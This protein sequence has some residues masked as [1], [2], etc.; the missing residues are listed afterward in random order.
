M[1]EEQLEIQ[2]GLFHG[3]NY[4]FKWFIFSCSNNLQIPRRNYYVILLC[5]MDYFLKSVF[6]ISNVPLSLSCR[7]TFLTDIKQMSSAGCFHIPR[8]KQ[9][10]KAKTGEKKI[11]NGLKIKLLAR[12]YVMYLVKTSQDYQP[13]LAASANLVL[14]FVFLVRFFFSGSV[15]KALRF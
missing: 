9:K 13:N 14:T 6:S 4:S 1:I 15:N 10:Q 11:S 3:F 2:S 5:Y 7:E 8:N 12:I